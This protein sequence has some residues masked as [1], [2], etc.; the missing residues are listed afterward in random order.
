MH[1]RGKQLILHSVAY[2]R[3]EA[4]ASQYRGIPFPPTS[5]FP[6]LSTGGDRSTGYTSVEGFLGGKDY[7]ICFFLWYYF[8]LQP[9]CLFYLFLFYFILLLACLTQIYRIHTLH[10][11]IMQQIKAYLNVHLICTNVQTNKNKSISE[12]HSFIWELILEYLELFIISL[13]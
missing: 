5:I 12:T 6:V 11:A 9:I 4:R 10:P 1:W 3:T 7:T 13:L 8:N 2:R